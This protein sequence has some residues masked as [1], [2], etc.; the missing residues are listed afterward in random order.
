MGYASQLTDS[1]GH[2]FLDFFG[3]ECEEVGAWAVHELLIHFVFRARYF[4]FASAAPQVSVFVL[5]YQYSKQ[6]ES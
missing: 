2:H 4:E 1:L 3:K 6:T 5:L